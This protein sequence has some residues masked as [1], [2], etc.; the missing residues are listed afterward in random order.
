MKL[1]RENN[2][3][4]T[5]L[6]VLVT[7]TVLTFGLLGVWGLQLSFLQG[8]IF[9][10]RD[11]E[12]MLRAQDLIAQ[13]QSW[14]FND[15]R[16]VNLDP[17]N[18]ANICNL[19]A[20]HGADNLFWNIANLDTDSDGAIDAYLI[21]VIATWTNP[22]GGTGTNIQSRCYLTVVYQPRRVM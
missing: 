12:S 9:A 11:M 15:P 7:V 18:D 2:S 22:I 19:P 5:F 8:N 4:F 6:E 14:N 1:R 10:R 16:F 13:M 3:G 17:G 20:E 21:G